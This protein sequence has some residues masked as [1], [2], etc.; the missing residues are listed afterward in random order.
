MTKFK[1]I[2]PIIGLIIG[3]CILAYF[4]VS[5]LIDSYK[6]AQ[7]IKGLNIKTA[8]LDDSQKKELL[9]Q[10]RSYNERL[11]G[12]QPETSNIWPYEHQLTFDGSSAPFAYVNIP[13]ISLNMPIYHG[14]S[15]EVLSA[16]VGH[17][18]GTSLPIGG[19]STHAVLSAHSGMQ[20]MRAFDDIRRLKKGDVFIVE[21]L[22]K[23]Y[24]YKVYKKEV[25]LP[26]RID[27][28][29]IQP[30]KDICTLM[31]CTPYGINTHR[32]L[33]TGK[34]CPVP[35]NIKNEHSLLGF[36]TNLRII[37]FIIAFVL[38]LG[39]LIRKLWQRKKFSQSKKKVREGKANT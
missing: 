20:R 22:N 32:L 16:G 31:T 38:T 15:N 5:E 37:P 24:A 17:V 11:A 14:T 8:K 28:F 35:K 2:V 27:K 3:L 10:A 33:V 21:V 26:D 39:M 1:R 30:G 7:V 25:V 4:P 9:L 13:K 6:R 34:R 12:M 36:I 19:K 18:K 23:K 29:A